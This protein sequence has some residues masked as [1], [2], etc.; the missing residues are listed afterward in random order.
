MKSKSISKQERKS[1]QILADD[2]GLIN[3]RD[4]QRIIE[5]R[6][7]YTEGHR[8]ILRIYNQAYM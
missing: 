6:S 5:S 8:A 1:L 7:S 4:V 2:F 3:R